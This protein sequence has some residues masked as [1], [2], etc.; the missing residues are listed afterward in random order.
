MKVLEIRTK[1]SKLEME[2]LANLQELKDLNQRQAHVDFEAML[3]QHRLS[4]EQWRQQQEEED[5]LETAALLQEAHHRRL[6]DDS[7]SED[8]APPS[9]PQAA[10]RP[11]PTAIL[12]KVPQTKRKNRGP[13]QQSTVGRLG[14]TKEGNDGG[15]QGLRASRSGCQ[16]L[17]PPRAE[18]WPT[19]HPRHLVPPL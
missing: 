11:N 15:Q 8:E 3:R 16:P 2:V 19:L 7:D 5:E 4:Q 1:D 12:D 9:R 14:C 6:P 13:V 10:V 17:V 18:T